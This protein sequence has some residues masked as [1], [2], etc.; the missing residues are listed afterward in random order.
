MKDI[1]LKITGKQYFKDM[2]E[3]QMEF[4]TEG[5]LY[6]RNGAVYVVYEESEISGMD[7]C[8]TTLRLKDDTV[9]MK[10][11]GMS[12][13]GSELYFEKGKRFTGVY[14]TPFGDMS[15]EVLTSAV[16]SYINAE[17]GT[18]RVDVSY[19]VSMEG[20][21]EGKNQITIDII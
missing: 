11:T 14:S 15:I 6:Q 12:G 13:Y 10:R 1:T 5:K 17:E 4:V 2:E 9:R 16:S 20:V 8:K 7:G 19:D 3:E 21:A 18:G